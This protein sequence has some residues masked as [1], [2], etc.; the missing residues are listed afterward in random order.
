M[1]FFTAGLN[2]AG[3]TIGSF[4]PVMCAYPSLPAESWVFVFFE[5]YNIPTPISESAPHSL[6][7]SNAERK[8]EQP[9]KTRKKRL[10]TYLATP[11]YLPPLQTPIITTITAP[12]SS[13]DCVRYGTT[14]PFMCLHLFLFYGARFLLRPSVVASTF[15]CG[16]PRICNCGLSLIKQDS[17]LNGYLQRRTVRIL[18][19]LLAN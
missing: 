18:L 16:F 14:A 12:R 2:V 7:R 6:C 5:L 13:S 4:S 3:A 10:F 9:K 1:L 17:N 15:F 11:A 19:F 8:P